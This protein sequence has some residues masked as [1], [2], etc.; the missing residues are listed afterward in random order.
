LGLNWVFYLKKKARPRNVLF[1][2][3]LTV[4]EKQQWLFSPVLSAVHKLPTAPMSFFA[5]QRTAAGLDT[6]LGFGAISAASAT[7]LAL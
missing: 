7:P 1:S 5:T 4:R 6:R 3:K 2:E